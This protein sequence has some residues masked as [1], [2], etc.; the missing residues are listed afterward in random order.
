[1]VS[2][3]LKKN[4]LHLTPSGVGMAKE[5]V[6]GASKLDE[7]AGAALYARRQEAVVHGL[8]FPVKH[9]GMPAFRTPA[10]F[11]T[12]QA[13]MSRV[14]SW[15]NAQ[16]VQVQPVS[17]S[18]VATAPSEPNASV[19]VWNVA[20]STVLP[21]ISGVPVP[22]LPPTSALSKSAEEC[23]RLLGRLDFLSKEK[24]SQDAPFVNER[25]SLLTQ[26][27]DAQRELGE[28][29]TRIAYLERQPNHV[30]SQQV[31]T[32][33]HENH[34]LTERLETADLYNRAVQ[35]NILK[36]FVPKASIIHDGTKHEL[37]KLEVVVEEGVRVLYWRCKA[38]GRGA[39]EQIA[40]A[41][42]VLVVVPAVFVGGSAGASARARH[43]SSVA[44]RAISRGM[45][46]A[47]F[48]KIVLCYYCVIA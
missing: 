14:F 27:A 43:T 46:V 4:H 18:H 36:G 47:H 13:Q 34:R 40:A 31:T 16:V 23:L 3:S 5:K 44:P 39:P 35:S 24:K 15:N 25:Q 28:A 21:P 22:A 32:L 2:E 38:N 45:F 11:L 8:M 48:P 29:R 30:Q 10:T 20:G 12:P 17:R 6:R 9:V 33:R 7:D 1:V 19:S 37:E 41:E 26:V 42:V